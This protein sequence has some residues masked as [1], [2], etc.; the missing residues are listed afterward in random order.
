V[1]TIT[2]IDYGLSNIDSVQRAFERLGAEVQIAES[3]ET[4]L[5]AERLVLPGVGAFGAGTSELRRRGMIGPL[6]EYLSGDRPFLGICLGMQL[7][8]DSSEESAES[9]GICAIPGR[10][11]H[12]AGL[13]AQSAKIPNVGWAPLVT[14]ARHPILERISPHESLYFV[15]SFVGTPES[16]LDVIATAGFGEMQFPAIVGRRKV[17]GCQFHPEK[18]GPTGLKVLSNFLKL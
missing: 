12:L 18:S 3:G 16:S 5:S 10:V 15:H 13:G 9:E 14:S 4:L 7:L 6:R 8:F 17:L 1:T 11:R 2:L